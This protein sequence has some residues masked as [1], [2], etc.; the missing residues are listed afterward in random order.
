[1]QSESRR[2]VG[3]KFGV[4]CP[5]FAKVGKVGAFAVF[6]RNTHD[7]D[8]ACELIAQVERFAS[9]GVCLVKEH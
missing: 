3:S 9:D 2:I 7:V 4:V 5:S 8:V 1:M 6:I